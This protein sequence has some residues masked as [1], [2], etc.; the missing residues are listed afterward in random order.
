MPRPGPLGAWPPRFSVSKGATCRCGE[1]HVALPFIST[2]TCAT[3]APCRHIEQADNGS[4]VPY[5]TNL[6]LKPSQGLATCALC[7]SF[8]T[9]ECMHTKVGKPASR[10]RMARL[11]LVCSLL[12]VAHCFH[13]VGGCTGPLA[14]PSSPRPQR[15]PRRSV[16]PVPQTPRAPRC[17]SQMHLSV[18]LMDRAHR[19][20]PII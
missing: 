12:A 5:C 8:S 11:F 6:L 3:R 15:Q 19:E 20:P 13:E 1:P 2:P 10:F 18:M 7:G 9:P 14:R 16:A 4:S 17:P